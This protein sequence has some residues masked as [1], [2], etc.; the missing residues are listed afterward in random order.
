VSL[1]EIMHG[2]SAHPDAARP[3]GDGDA[4]RPVGLLEVTVYPSG[5]VAA[6]YHW[7]RRLFVSV[8][9]VEGWL[10]GNL[11]PSWQE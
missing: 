11:P 4:A 10:D 9:E 8:D 3:S 7:G 5:S 6:L 2:L 1:G